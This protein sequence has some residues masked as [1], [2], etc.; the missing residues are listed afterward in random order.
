MNKGSERADARRNRER[1]LEA[2]RHLF[3]ERGIDVDVREI[4]ERSG[5]GVATLYRNFATKEDLIT[6]IIEQVTEEVRAGMSR[7]HDEQDPRRA[8]IVL[9]DELLA[10]VE[11]HHE[12][13]A[14]SP[15]RARKSTRSSTS[16]FLPRQRRSLRAAQRAHLVRTDV[17]AR[18]LVEAVGGFMGTY[19]E[20]LRTQ[21][22]AT[23]RRGGHPDA[24]ERPARDRRRRPDSRGFHRPRLS[25][26]SSVPYTRYLTAGVAQWQSSCFVNSRSWVQVPPPAPDNL[27][28]APE[29]A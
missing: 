21:R 26:G 18:I 4:C 14:S 8:L 2:A 10:I 13:L 11:R 19:V 25:L 5:V 28:R 3:A 22:Q 1:L 16:T 23:A 20:L 24:L 17:S 29:T 7:A 9:L 15:N 27:V 12:W 6:A